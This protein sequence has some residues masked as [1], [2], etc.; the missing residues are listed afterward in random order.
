MNKPILVQNNEEWLRLA[1]VLEKQGYVWSHGKKPTEFYPLLNPNTPFLVLNNH[2]KYLRFK[3]KF[4]EPTQTVDEYLALQEQIGDVFDILDLGQT[5]GKPPKEPNSKALYEAQSKAILEA[6]AEMEE[7]E[8]KLSRS[9]NNY[10]ED[11][12]KGVEQAIQILKEKL[13]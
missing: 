4:D 1:P 3:V 2:K 7:V 5:N 9:G 13:G 6:I 12:A 11:K 8:H 10:E